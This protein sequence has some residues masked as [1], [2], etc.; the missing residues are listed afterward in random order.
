M[1]VLLLLINC[2]L[3]VRVLCLVLFCK[4]VLLLLLVLQS[5]R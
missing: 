5:S 4:P 2:S 3:P 1:V